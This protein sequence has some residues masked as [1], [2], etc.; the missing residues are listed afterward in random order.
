MSQDRSAR[1]VSEQERD[2]MVRAARRFYLDDVSKSAIA[3]ELGVS[4]FRVARLLQAARAQGIVRV[5]IEDTSALS[6]DLA[7]QVTRVLGLRRCAVLDARHSGPAADV[8]AELGVLAA[9]ELQD[10]LTPTDV[11]GLPWSRSVVAMARALTA[12]PPVPVVQLSGDRWTPDGQPASVDV[13]RDVAAIA[14][15]PAY[16]FHAPLV[17]RDA[18]A[19]QALREDPA[20]R[21]AHGRVASITVAV[22]GIGAFRPG[23]STLYAA[24]SEREVAE[25]LDAGAVAE[26]CGAFVDEAGG[27]VCGSFTER[28]LTVDCP[29]LRAVPHVIGVCLGADR[30]PAVLAAHRGGLLDSLV[31]DMPLARGL[32]DADYRSGRG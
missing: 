22:V 24:A 5:S 3:Q 26:V 11:L 15:G 12:L 9:R 7:A 29:A 14:G 4:R 25:L 18:R 2:L 19:A 20:Y 27:A 31:I 21:G 32:V 1:L 23:L 28:L 10:L 17:A 6:A 30:A 16:R 8:R 13:V